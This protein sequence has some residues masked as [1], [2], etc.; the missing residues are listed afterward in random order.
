MA[1]DFRAP[2]FPPAF[3]GTMWL[4]KDGSVGA[5]ISDVF[6]VPIHI[7]AKK[8]GD[9]YHVRG[10]RG[11]PPEFVR[12]PLE[13]TRDDGLPDDAPHDACGKCE[14]RLF[15]RASIV[16]GGDGGKG[17]WHCAACEAMDPKLWMD[18][19]VVPAKRAP[20][21]VKPVEKAKEKEG[22]LL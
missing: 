18:G 5:E 11:E 12:L 17:L 22:T 4:N 1:K 10:W 21:V 2:P 9:H 15:W 20:V 14:G 13:Y 3:T 16:N 6:N 7:I 8:E 19:L